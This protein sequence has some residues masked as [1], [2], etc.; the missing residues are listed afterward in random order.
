MSNPKVYFDMSIGGK[1]AGRVI[2][3]LRADVV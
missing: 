1:S 2:M 3:E